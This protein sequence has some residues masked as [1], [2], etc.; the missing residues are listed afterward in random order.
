MVRSAL[1][2]VAWVGRTASMVFGLAL[3]MALVVGV[4]SAAFGANGQAWILGRANVATA[5]TSLGGTLG[6]NGPML[7]ITNN[8]EGTNDTA[9]ALNVQSGE[10][11]M[12]VNSPT[13]VANLNA[14]RIDNREASSFANAT[15]GHS[16]ADIRSG[17]VAEA[18]IDGTVARDS[19]IMPTVQANDGPGS[20]LDADRLDNKDSND[21]AVRTSFAVGPGNSPSGT[22]QFLVNPAIVDVSAGQAVHVTSNSAFGTTF[23]GGA[24]NLDLSICHQPLGS[25]NVLIP[26]GQAIGGIRVAQNTRVPMGLSGVITGL[27]AG[28]HQVGL[29]GTGD[30]NWNSNSDY[31]YTSAMVLTQP[32]A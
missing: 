1:S 12:Q 6:V 30:A 7:A 19:E 28:H 21:L 8:N 14:D 2:K 23:S 18:H 13:K 3:V 15:H 31:G 20:G 27:S 22:L 4:A 11:P 25:T 24:G 29:C 9:L 32:S 16:G 17:T 10:A 26:V 5:I